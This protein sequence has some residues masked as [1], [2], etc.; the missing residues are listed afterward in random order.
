MKGVSTDISRQVF[1]QVVGDHR[2]TESLDPLLRQIFLECDGHRT[3]A[4]VAVKIGREPTHL[5]N[6]VTRLI[7]M[8]L[9]RAVGTGA[10]WT[11]RHFFRALSLAL[12][13]AV[14]PIA[15][16]LID[17][18]IDAL[19]HPRDRFPAELAADLVDALAREVQ[20]GDKRTAFQV[21]MVRLIRAKR[22]AA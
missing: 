18:E 5:E 10:R 11:D 12:S 21:E 14:G 22:Y 13:R 9:I 8:N 15:P 1:R 19:G 4:E 16:V 3:I 7:E 20:P 6:A 2:T 17:E